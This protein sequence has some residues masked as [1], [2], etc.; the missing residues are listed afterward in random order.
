MEEDTRSERQA[1]G[2]WRRLANTLKQF[3]TR[4]SQQCINY[5]PHNHPHQARMST[6]LHTIAKTGCPVWQLDSGLVVW[7]GNATINGDGANGRTGGIACYRPDNS[8]LDDIQNAHDPRGETL[9]D[10]WPG[11]LVLGDTKILQGETDPDPGA[12]ISTTAY[13]WRHLPV[14]DVDRYVDSAA[15]PGL[16]VPSIVRR[17][18]KGVAIGSQGWITRISTGQRIP[19]VSYDEGPSEDSGEMSIA[20]AIE[21]EIPADPRNGG[22]DEVDFLYSFMPGRAANI[23]GTVYALIPMGS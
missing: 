20:A 13:Q 22:T 21:L 8:G 12:Y 23:N 16:V 4:N 3:G 19:C 5:D 2:A 17:L 1:I 11:L 18:C 6:K 7:Q 14:R 15:V 10:Q 9:V